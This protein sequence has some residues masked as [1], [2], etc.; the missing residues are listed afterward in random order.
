MNVVMTNSRH[1]D[2]EIPE[3]GVVEKSITIPVRTKGNTSG[4]LSLPGMEKKHAAIIVAHGAGN[5]MNTPL[6]TSY[7]RGLA[8]SGYPVLRFNFLY[9]E[10]GRKSPDKQ[11]VLV[12][13]WESAYQSAR[14]ELG[15]TVDTWIAAGKSMG[16]RVAS[17]MV[18]DYQLPV[19]GLVFL[20]YPLHPA[21]DHENL[22]DEHLY[23]I[24]QP[25]LFFA[26][27]RDPL[28]A[29]GKLNGVL[30]HLQASREL[31][32]IDGGDHSFHVLKSTGMTEQEIHGQIIRVT[33][34]W[35]SRILA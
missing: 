5:D 29:M 10:L 14:E 12:E 35:L 25:M 19:H 1:I 3:H 31:F 16:G 6:I 26:G 11:K 20:G 15:G 34:E 2:K 24:T 21:G 28:C 9:A 18:A 4:I 8:S 32:I 13:T 27:T 23:R 33:N 30:S 7:C 17:Q 22:R